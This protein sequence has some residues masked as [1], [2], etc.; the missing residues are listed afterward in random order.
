ML[1]LEGTEHRTARS[2]GG[3]RQTAEANVQSAVKA[4]EGAV[5]GLKAV[6]HEVVAG[7]RGRQKHWLI[8]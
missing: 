1:L 4:V 5:Q 6:V 3:L 7:L 2:L 8:L